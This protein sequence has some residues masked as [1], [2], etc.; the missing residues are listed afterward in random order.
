M[1]YAICCFLALLLA[2]C[3]PK[4]ISQNE[5]NITIEFPYEAQ[6][7]AFK[8]AEEHCRAQGKVA[9]LSTQQFFP[10]GGGGVNSWR[11]E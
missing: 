10:H 11:C 4:V 7:D 8:M 2:G 9:V 1:R 5:K 3:A 6:S